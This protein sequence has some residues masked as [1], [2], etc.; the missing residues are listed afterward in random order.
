MQRR[1]ES[2]IWKGLY[3]PPVLERNSQRSPLKKHVAS[4]IENLVGHNH[5][6]YMSST[7]AAKQILSHQT[8]IGSFHHISLLSP[9]KINH[10]LSVWARE[11]D[12]RKLAKPKLVGL[13]I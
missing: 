2:D 11:D 6:E 1:E 3:A 8:I 7:G 12:L 4:F 10:P 13:G 9:V 5:V